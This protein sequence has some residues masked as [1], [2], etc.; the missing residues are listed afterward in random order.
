MTCLDWASAAGIVLPQQAFDYRQRVA[1]RSAYQA[2][3][4][5]NFPSA[6]TV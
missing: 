6:T 3:L 5:R 4:K 1:Q 2:A